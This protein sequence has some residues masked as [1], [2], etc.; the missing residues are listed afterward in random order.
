[1]KTK[2]DGYL[3]LMPDG[4]FIFQTMDHEERTG[5]KIG[6]TRRWRVH[7]EDEYLM[8]IDAADTMLERL[9]K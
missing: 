9:A 2:H 1:M 4:E 7:D 5:M 6:F 3:F 8:A